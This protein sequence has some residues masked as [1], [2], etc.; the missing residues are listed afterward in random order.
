MFFGG[1]KDPVHSK[2]SKLLESSPILRGE[3]TN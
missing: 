2:I 1:H 3:M